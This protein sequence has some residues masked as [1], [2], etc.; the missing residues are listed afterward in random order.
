MPH[1]DDNSIQFVWLV[2]VHLTFVDNEETR[3]IF[4]MSV[5]T[6]NRSSVA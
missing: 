4:A 2:W 6:R 3:S 5:Q 1:Y